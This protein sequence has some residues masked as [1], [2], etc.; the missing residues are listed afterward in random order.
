MTLNTEEL[1]TNRPAKHSTFLKA[2]AQQSHL[3]TQQANAVF[4]CIIE[5]FSHALA[6]GQR[7]DI[8]DFGSLSATI[9]HGHAGN[10]SNKHSQQTTL[11]NCRIRF[12]PAKS[13][14]QSL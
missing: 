4:E 8:R 11:Q 5:Q 14:W 12:K 3:T 6:Q 10:F 7:I 13:L 1:L 2:F 9:R